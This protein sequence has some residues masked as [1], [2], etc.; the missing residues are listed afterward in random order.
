[1]DNVTISTSIKTQQLCVNSCTTNRNKEPECGKN[2]H[3]TEENFSSADFANSDQP[4]SDVTCTR[5]KTKRNK[6]PLTSTI[7]CPREGCNKIFKNNY[8]LK[9]HLQRHEVSL[10]KFLNSYLF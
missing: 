1:L 4:N 3:N 7:T 5:K 9:L 2:F 8:L 6:E 10:Y